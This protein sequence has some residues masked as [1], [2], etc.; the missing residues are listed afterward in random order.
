MDKLAFTSETQ[1]ENGAMSIVRQSYSVCRGCMSI[2]PCMTSHDG[3]LAHA[4]VDM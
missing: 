3:L 2:H 4:I 1:N